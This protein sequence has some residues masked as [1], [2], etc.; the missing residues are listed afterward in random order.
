MVVHDPDEDDSCEAEGGAHREVELAA[1]HED[2]G[3][4]RQ[5]RENG[6]ALRDHA[7]QIAR[8]QEREAVGDRQARHDERDDDQAVDDADLESA[9]PAQV[10]DVL[11]E[12]TPGR[13]GLAVREPPL[14]GPLLEREGRGRHERAVAALLGLRHR[15]PL[16]VSASRRL[17]GDPAGGEGAGR[18]AWIDRPAPSSWCYQRTP[19]RDLSSRLPTLV[20]SIRPLPPELM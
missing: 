14:R 5:Q 13:R 1:D 9:S 15:L 19:W 12:A 3:A 6:D 10:V 20:L 2:A 16:L 4:D 17:G 11:L 8:A 7:R 18:P